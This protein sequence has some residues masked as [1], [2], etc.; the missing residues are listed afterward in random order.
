MA[1]LLP[2]WAVGHNHGGF[3]MR[4][5]L[6]TGLLAAC[7]ASM[8]AHASQAYGSIN[9]FDAVNDCQQECHGF[10]IEIE[11][12]H[13]TDVTYTYDYNHYGTPR[14]TEDNTDPLHPRVIVR[15]EARYNGDGTWSAY[16]AIPA[17]PVLP[18]D[19][20]HVRGPERELWR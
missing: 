17:G 15:Y 6:L 13:S 8:Q 1:T 2:P 12:A 18:T 3:P 4:K 19:G 9:N 10:E 7:V 14:I 16:T 11:D 20:H 5:V